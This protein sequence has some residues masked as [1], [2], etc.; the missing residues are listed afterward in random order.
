MRAEVGDRIRVKTRGAQSRGGDIR[1]GEITAVVGELG[2]QLYVVTYDDGEEA[3]VLPG[4]TV[5]ILR[6]E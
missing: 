6:T 4:P 3:T 1:E 2:R 5:T